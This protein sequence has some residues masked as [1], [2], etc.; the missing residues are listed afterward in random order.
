MCGIGSGRDWLGE[1]GSRGPGCDEEEFAVTELELIGADSMQAETGS[2]E[3]GVGIPAANG[4][5][6]CFGARA[7]RS[8]IRW[9]ILGVVFGFCISSVGATADRPER[10]G[11][12]GVQ[13]RASLAGLRIANGR[14]LTNGW[15]EGYSLSNAMLTGGGNG[16]LENAG[17]A[18]FVSGLSPYLRQGMPQQPDNYAGLQA[19]D[20]YHLAGE[21]QPLPLHLEIFAWLFF[22]GFV[23]WSGMAW[24]GRR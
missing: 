7:A 15:A 16:I 10:D 13:S 2:R 6:V 17:V 22:C 23:S 4:V 5:A 24:M 9:L 18:L 21:Q 1:A 14:R 19:P 11:G 3:I 20:E 12:N 8:M